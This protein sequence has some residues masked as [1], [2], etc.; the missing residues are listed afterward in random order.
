M[1]FD[2]LDGFLVVQPIRLP[3]R[4]KTYEFPGSIPARTGLLLQ[5]LAAEADRARSG[6]TE[7]ADLA[8]EVLSDDEE[9]DL[10]GEIMGKAEQ[11]MADDGLTTAHTRH[12]FQTLLVWHMAGPEA[13]ERA[14]RTLGEAKPPNRAER[15][16]ASKGSASTTRSPGSGSGTTTR[17]PRPVEAVS[18]GPA[19]SRSGAA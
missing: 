6:D 8:T 18:P 11:E 7:P 12:V 16:A 4:G 3:I 15:R 19:S 5:R 1:A 17:R 9:V 10:R 14:W 2:D 13:A